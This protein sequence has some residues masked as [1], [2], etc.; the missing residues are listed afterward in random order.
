MPNAWRACGR[1]GICPTPS[2][3]RSHRRTYRLR[4]VDGR[5]MRTYEKALELASTQELV[6][7]NGRPIRQDDE[8]HLERDDLH[9]AAASG[10]ARSWAEHTG[11][12]HNRYRWPVAM[13]GV[14]RA[15][16]DL[17]GAL[18]LLNEAERLYRGFSPRYVRSRR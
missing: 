5:A 3:L 16:G 11:L 2:V 1:Q 10:E 12:P 13:A 6:E 14:C 9:A 8:L 7:G 4:R 15:Q 17:P 18:D